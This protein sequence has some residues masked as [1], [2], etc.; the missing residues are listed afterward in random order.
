M[1]KKML[2]V[3]LALLMVLAFVIPTA[4]AAPLDWLCE[5]RADRVIE[6][7][8]DVLNTAEDILIDWDITCDANLDYLEDA[9][10]ELDNATDADDCEEVIRYGARS[11]LYSVLAVLKPCDDDE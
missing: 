7:A 11:I 3:A 1:K 5:A 2:F 6:V 8:E 4:S 9:Q 10:I